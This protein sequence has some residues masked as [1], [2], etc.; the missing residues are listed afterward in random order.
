[1]C[2]V[3]CEG[4]ADVYCFSVTVINTVKI[5]K[6]AQRVPAEH[7]SLLSCCMCIAF[8]CFL[9]REVGHIRAD[10]IVAAQRPMPPPMHC[11]FTRYNTV[12][13]V[14]RICFKVNVV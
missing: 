1:M 12:V 14:H 4:A 3:L 6:G 9:Q 8:A 2:S 5:S 10:D 11:S 7:I 13:F